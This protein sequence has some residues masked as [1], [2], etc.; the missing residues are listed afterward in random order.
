ML[1]KNDWRDEIR[2]TWFQGGA[3]PKSPSK[4]V[5]LK[6]IGH[7]AMFKGDKGFIIA[8]FTNRII[9]PNGRDGNLSYFKPR[10]EG[11]LT[12]DL[13]AFHEEWTNACKN[14]KPADTACNFE[15]SANMIENMCL[16]LAAFRAGTELQY[17]GSKGVIT[18]NAEANQYLSKP[19]RKGWTLNG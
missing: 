9:L 14:G 8:D 6:K 19:Y 4:W 18:N 12:A 13:G 11:E 3:M 5:D 1:P 15:Y 10:G 7:G 16:G 17:D 2:C